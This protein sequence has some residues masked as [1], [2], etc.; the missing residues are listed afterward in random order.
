MGIPFFARK[1]TSKYDIIT[2]KLPAKT[3]CR[4]LYL[5]LNCAI[6]QCAQA[7]LAMPPAALA[8]VGGVEDQ[9]VRNTC[10]Y[11]AK[12]LDFCKPKS[13][14]YVAIDGLPPRAKMVQQRKRRYVSAWSSTPN[15]KQKAW[16]T[17]AI[18]PGTAFMTKLSIG[19]R[20][21]LEEQGRAR[22][23]RI[24]FFDSDTPG[25]GETKIVDH[26]RAQD[27]GGDG[28]ADVIYGL[29][30]DLIML[31]M[32]LEHD[33]FL[34]RE[35]AAYNRFH[36][37]QPFLYFD[38]A[39][40]K[41]HICT[42]HDVTPHEFVFLCFLM[43]N[44]F[45]PPLSFLSI[46]SDGI[47]AVLKLY[48][49]LRESH[50]PIVAERPSGGRPDVNFKTLLALFER[51]KD[52]EDESM[53]KADEEY[54]AH[55]PRYA[56]HGPKRQFELDNFPSLNKFPS[57]LIR[58]SDKGWRLNYYHHLF[59]I[60]D[61]PDIHAVCL[62]YMEGLLWT[63][64]YYYGHAPTKTWYYQYAYSPTI[65]D[66][67]N[68]MVAQQITADTLVSSMRER[69]DAMRAFYDAPTTASPPAATPEE[70]QLLMVLPPSS[71]DLLPVHLRPVM[72]EL[73]HLYPASFRIHTYLKRFMWECHP[74][75]PPL[76]AS[77]IAR[78]AAKKDRGSVNQL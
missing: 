52:A 5:D 50:G 23:L 65:L 7:A 34:L 43:G 53:R 78:C 2:T 11:I 27:V 74:V 60:N 42:E 46:R 40:L 59:H 4:N 3:R 69:F 58:P 55:V 62:N 68:F 51:L 20:G 61:V 9:T 36:A 73:A 24:E 48:R 37:P 14:L 72:A 49:S 13:L 10:A 38:I 41:H 17:S 76:N 75:L 33:I 57:H 35:P 25:E 16:D 22:K 8:L 64:M 56:G 19:L 12:I 47:E 66:L 6:H 45:L 26:L 15:T 63:L 70:L 44:D 18:T 77:L 30:A 67:C 39:K 54:Y 21:F 71:A 31:S 32:G 28:N 29:D 1:I